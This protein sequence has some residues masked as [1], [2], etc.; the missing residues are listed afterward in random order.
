MSER[1]IIISIIIIVARERAQLYTLISSHIVH[2]TLLCVTT[3]HRYKVSLPN[4]VSVGKEVK[5]AG[6]RGKA[7]TST[8]QRLVN[9]DVFSHAT[10]T[11]RFIRRRTGGRVVGR[12]VVGRRGC[13]RHG[14][15]PSKAVYASTKA[16]KGGGRVRAL[17]G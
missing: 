8:N 6:T 1:Y 3:V 16:S 4:T 11:L 13:N 7:S 17:I 10:L 9:M 15:V 5:R 14:D 2:S 12:E